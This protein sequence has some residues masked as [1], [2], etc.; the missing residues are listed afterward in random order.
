MQFLGVPRFFKDVIRLRV[1]RTFSDIFKH[2]NRYKISTTILE[3]NIRSNYIK[4]TIAC[5]HRKFIIHVN[6][7]L[8]NDK[9]KKLYV[10]NFLKEKKK[11]IFH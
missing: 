7:I 8:V 2:D 9:L 4:K 1:L 5:L 3:T 10:D 6:D 11:L